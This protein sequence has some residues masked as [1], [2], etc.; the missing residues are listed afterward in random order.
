ML[1]TDKQYL[2]LVADALAKEILPELVNPGP[3]SA[4]EYSI[5]ALLELIKRADHLPAQINERSAAGLALAD[6]LVQLGASDAAEVAALRDRFAREKQHPESAFSALLTLLDDGGKALLANRSSDRVTTSWLRDAADWEC[7]YYT[8]FAATPTPE[9]SVDATAKPLTPAKLQRHLRARLDQPAL[10]V[11]DFIGIP[12]G[13]CNETFFC[14]LRSPGEADRRVVVR[15]NT[16][17]PL[18]DFGAHRVT[19]EFG[20]LSCLSDQGLR[21]AKPLWLFR[22]LPDVDGNFYLTT[23]GAGRKVGGLDGA[24]EEL[25]ERLLLSVAEF[26]AQLHAIPPERFAPYYPPSDSPLHLGDTAEQAVRRYVDQFYRVWSTTDRFPSPAEAF[27]ID[28]LR[29]NVPKNRNPAV[30]LHTDCFVH[31]FLVDDNNEIATVLDWECSHFGDPAEDLAYIKEHI[32]ARMDWD[33]F[34]DHYLA[35]GGQPIDRDSM[36]YYNALLYFR[37][38]WGCNKG[39]MR[40]ATGLSDVKMITLGSAH[41]TRYMKLCIDDAVA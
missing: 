41:R 36:G 21:V 17:D 23:F 24:T 7:A 2:Q 20:T 8:T 6:R 35:S 31:N 25:P 12:G 11:T 10:E 1:L 27:A 22:D 16:P 5:S 39:V 4:A 9:I 34:I 3:R 40:V 28:W 18:F 37:N 26:M 19:E 14:T 38:F 30:M 29:R 33:R 32:S 15:K 13:M